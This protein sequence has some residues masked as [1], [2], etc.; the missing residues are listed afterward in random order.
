MAPLICTC[1]PRYNPPS[2]FPC[3]R[4]PLHY[5]LFLWLLW[6]SS[7]FDPLPLPAASLIN[8]CSCC[9][10]FP[11]FVLLLCLLCGCFCFYL[12]KS[13][14]FCPTP[15]LIYLTLCCGSFLDYL[16]LWLL[17]D[18]LLLLLHLFSCF[19]LLLCTNSVDGFCFCLDESSSFFPTPRLI[20]LMLC[21]GSFPDYLLL[22]QQGY[23]P[24]IIGLCALMTP[25]LLL[26]ETNC[27]SNQRLFFRSVPRHVAFW[28]WPWHTQIVK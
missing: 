1:L 3:T 25:F 4:T 23:Y 20:S 21:C 14:S 16:L 5:L 24:W 12:N 2:S 27:E 6:F 7:C 17:L 10:S 11:C 26:E 15:G 19:L 18:I 22:W 13:S 9:T 8:C 28:N